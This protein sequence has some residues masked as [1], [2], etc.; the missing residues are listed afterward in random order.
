MKLQKIDNNKVEHGGWVGDIPDMGD[1]RIYTKGTNSSGY[2]KLQQTLMAAVP[3]SERHQGRISPA[4]MDAISA[5]CLLNQ[6]LLGW[7]NLDADDSPGPG[8]EGRKLVPYSKEQAEIYLTD[9]A[10]RP[11]FE[12]CAYAATIVGEEQAEADK[13]D[14]G[15]S[16]T[17]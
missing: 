17:A 15:N 4:R 13:A 7:D 3:R 9:P 5:S 11:F 10:Y 2:R 16:P 6:A 12:A 8:K 1:L 14:E